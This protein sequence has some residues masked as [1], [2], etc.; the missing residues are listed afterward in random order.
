M[1]F[2]GMLHSASVDMQEIKKPMQK[3]ATKPLTRVARLKLQQLLSNRP[4]PAVANP[5]SMSCPPPEEPSRPDP[6]P[7]RASFVNICVFFFKKHA[8]GK[9]ADALQVE[10]IVKNAS[11]LASQ[12]YHSGVGWSNDIFDVSAPASC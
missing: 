1:I 11:D 6:D 2:I 10:G 9:M 5:K 8:P 12:L 7:R 3:H 4:V